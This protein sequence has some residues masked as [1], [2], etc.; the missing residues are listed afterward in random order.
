[1]WIMAQL[2]TKGEIKY[3]KIN[4]DKLKKQEIQKNC[5]KKNGHRGKNFIQRDNKNM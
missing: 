1:M 3:K 4:V 5:K 2:G